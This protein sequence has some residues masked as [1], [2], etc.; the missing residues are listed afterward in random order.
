[1]FNIFKS[2]ALPPPKQEPDYASV[3]DDYT[4][5]INQLWTEQMQQELSRQ[6]V[7]GTGLVGGGLGGVRVTS[8]SVAPG[9]MLT[10]VPASRYRTI[11]ITV[12]ETSNGHLIQVG[13]IKRICP[14]S[15]NL[16]EAIAATIAEFEMDLADAKNR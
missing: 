14:S 16:P 10:D 5:Q 7:L 15:D 9:Q 4:K 13:R 11:H 12:E 8:S 6:Q 1:M 3:S 2:A